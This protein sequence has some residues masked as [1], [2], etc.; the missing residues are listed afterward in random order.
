MICIDCVTDVSLKK[1][2]AEHGKDHACQYCGRDRI[3]VEPKFLFDHILERTV[4]NTATENDL[5]IYE[6]GMT[7]D[8]GSDEISVSYLD[9]V[10]SEWMNLGEEA[11]FDDLYKYAPKK[12]KKDNGGMDRLYFEDDGS[13]E[14][15]FYEERW[16]RFVADVRHSH[17]FFNLNAKDF[18]DSVFAFLSGDRDVLK[19]E[20]VRVIPKGMPLYRARSASTYE[21]VKKIADAPASQLGPTPKNRASSQRMTPSGISALYCALERETCLSE[22][23]AITGDNVVSIAMTPT[24]E[25]KFLDLTKLEQVERPKLTPLEKGYRDALHLKTFVN[26]L[27]KKMSKPKGRADELSY[28][29]TQV[30]FEYLRLRFAGQVDGL[31]FPSVQTGEQGSNVVLFPEASVVSAKNYVNLF[32][33]EIA[34][35]SE[36]NF[37]YE[38]EE[39]FED[40]AKLYCLSGSLRF[41]KIKAIVTKASEYTEISELFMSDLYRDRL[42]LI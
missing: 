42:G 8:C 4:E 11:Y 17:R 28:L 27:V 18:L 31:I 30:V 26:S 1:L 38:K 32:D 23:R 41:H 15:N 33:G 12:L 5:S 9:V 2:I 29:S 13:L 3:A 6:Y 7:V 40:G 22:I 14:K 35:F 21:D 25:L 24:S 37:E 20:C 19:P 39:A 10:L 36:P 34:K 16:E